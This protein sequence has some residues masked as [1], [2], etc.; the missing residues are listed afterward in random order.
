LKN[1]SFSFKIGYLRRHIY[2]TIARSKKRTFR[3]R[4]YTDPVGGI[5]YLRIIMG[6][7]MAL[8]GETICRSTA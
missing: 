4:Q 6:Y 7:R 2:G 3:Y 1:K 8:P 5:Y